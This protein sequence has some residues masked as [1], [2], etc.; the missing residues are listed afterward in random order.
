MMGGAHFQRGKVCEELVRFF[1]FFF[2]REG[3]GRSEKL[4][5]SFLSFVFPRLRSRAPPAMA[6]AAAPPRASAMM[7]PSAATASIGSRRIG[8]GQRRTMPS[9]RRRPAMPTPTPTTTS[10]KS[11]LANPPSA[12]PPSRDSDPL[13]RAARS[14]VRAARSAA[15]KLKLKEK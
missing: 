14:T 4:S 9:F 1:F 7:S 2:F 5:P 15:E 12:N 6:F 8:G 10:A 3:D 11:P 13:V